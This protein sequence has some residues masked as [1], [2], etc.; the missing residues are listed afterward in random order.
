VLAGRSVHCLPQHSCSRGPARAGL[1]RLDHVVDVAALGRTYGL[2]I[3]RVL[4][5]QLLAPGDGVLAV[6]RS[7]CR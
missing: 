6:L 2:R 1:A 5:D 4:G 7:R 3:G